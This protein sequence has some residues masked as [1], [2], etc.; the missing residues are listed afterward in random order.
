LDAAISYSAQLG[1]IAPELT[2]LCVA[3][4]VLAVD[5]W[6]KGK[7]GKL[8]AWLSIAGLCL[9]GALLYGQTGE[10]Q[11]VLNM[12]EIDQFGRFFKLFTCA[13]IVVV[14]I[15]VLNDRQQRLDDVGE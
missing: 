15:L 1:A 12:V 10:P 7:D 8:L 11:T 3:L 6:T 13:S 2:L 5:L 9:V 14:I 4:V